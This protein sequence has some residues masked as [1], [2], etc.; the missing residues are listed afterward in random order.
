M[1]THAPVHHFN[2]FPVFLEKLRV[3][4]FVDPNKLTLLEHVSDGFI[5]NVHLFVHE[6]EFGL[7]ELHKGPCQAIFV[8]FYEVGHQV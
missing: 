5:A 8:R 1:A 3:A 6:F 7:D 2:Y 4:E